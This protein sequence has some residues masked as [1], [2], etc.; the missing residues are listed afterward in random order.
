MN[1]TTVFLYKRLLSYTWRYKLRL[2][3]ALLAIIF[4][5]LTEAS[6]SALLKPILDRGFVAQDPTFLRWMPVIIIVAFFVMSLFSFI[7]NVGM[8]WIAQRVVMELRQ[9]MFT[10]L[11]HLP[12]RQFDAQPTGMLLSKLTYDVTQLLTISSFALVTL[13][14][15]SA[16]I[17]GLLVVMFVINWQLSLIALLTAPVIAVMLRFVSKRLRKLARHVQG[18]M[19][20]LNHVVEETIRGH[21]ELRLFNAFDE[22]N[23]RFSMINK[24]L[25]RLNVRIMVV[26]EVAS[27]LSQLMIVLCVAG[28]IYYASAQVAENTLTVGGFLSLLAALVMLLNPIKRLTRLNESLQKGLAAA[29]SIFE[30]LDQPAETDQTTAQSITRLKGELCFDQV[31]FR[32]SAELPLALSNI[33]FELPAGKMLAL[34]GHSGSGKTTLAHLL[35]HFDVPESGKIKIDNQLISDMPLSAYRHNIAYVGQNVTLFA[36]TIL[37]NLTLGQKHRTLEE[38]IQA[39]KNAYI[40]D[41]IMSLPLGFETVIGENGTRLSG[42]Q[43]QR[44]ALARAFLKDAP[45]LI[46]DEATSHLDNE[47]EYYI[48][49]AL[50]LLRQNRTVVVIAH[51]L[52]TIEKADLILVLQKGHI[53]ESGQHQTLL[54]QEG[55]YYSLYQLGIQQQS[56]EKSVIT[57]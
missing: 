55:V 4:A 42:G 9:A 43:R 35:A 44:L 37:N 8:Q 33:S 22:V 30:L 48:Q 14:K 50:Q 18:Q 6:L 53:V 25:M 47:S 27:P 24:K 36:D 31:S 1:H 29:E 15:D 12:V 10:Q 28:I 52:T 54:Q 32:Y 7:G 20:E 17:L 51:R 3:I 16:T 5:G 39:C 34:V 21:K 40:Y 49:Q 41:F 26:S 45:L 11:L 19:G 56:S 46:L 13:V 2:F 57:E 23:Q 38:V